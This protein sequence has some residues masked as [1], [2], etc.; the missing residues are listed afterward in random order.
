VTALTVVSPD[1]QSVFGAAC[2]ANWPRVGSLPELASTLDTV[3]SNGPV[4]LE[5]VGH[6]TRGARLL[7]LGSSVIDMLDPAVSRFFLALGWSGILARRGVTAVRLLGCET[8]GTEAGRLTIRMLSRTLRLP[9]YGA[10]V[11]LR[12]VH[13]TVDGFDDAFAHLLVEASEL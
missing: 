8:A 11:P 1:A 5:L 4:T 13:S 6:S 7:R 3:A 2:S 9:V 10:R 12:A